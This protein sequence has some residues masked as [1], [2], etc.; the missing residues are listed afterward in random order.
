MYVSCHHK[1][2]DNNQQCIIAFSLEVC[3]RHF[4][5][6]ACYYCAA[7]TANVYFV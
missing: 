3:Y 7:V 4:M 6:L 1:H 5:L 2:L